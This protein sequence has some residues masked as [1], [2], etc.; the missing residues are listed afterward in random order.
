[1]NGQGIIVD[2]GMGLNFFDEELVKAS[3]R[4]S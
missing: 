3:S 1:V 2:A 4:I